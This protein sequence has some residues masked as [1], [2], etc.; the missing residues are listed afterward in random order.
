MLQ[1]LLE[2]ILKQRLHYSV[3]FFKEI[4]NFSRLSSKITLSSRLFGVTFISL[5]CISVDIFV[6]IAG[7]YHGEQDVIVGGI[8]GSTS[9]MLTIGIAMILISHR[10][11]VPLE[12]S[13]S[14]R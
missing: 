7:V 5:S 9:F 11:G 8:M 13:T 12:I 3:F 4:S 10:P 2:G 14:C 6:A 1:T